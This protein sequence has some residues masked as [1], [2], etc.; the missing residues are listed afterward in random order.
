MHRLLKHLCEITLYPLWQHRPHGIL[1]HYTVAICTNRQKTARTRTPNQICPYFL[2]SGGFR[3]SS[4]ST[5]LAE[6]PLS[7]LRACLSL[8][9]I[10]LPKW[11]RLEITCG[12]FNARVNRLRLPK[13]PSQ[14]WIHKYYMILLF[15]FLFFFPV[16]RD[17]RR[18][19]PHHTHTLISQSL[20]LFLP[21]TFACTAVLCA[22]VCPWARTSIFVRTG[23]SFRPWEGGHLW[24]VRTLWSLLTFWQTFKGAFWGFGLG[25][26]L[27]WC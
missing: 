24:N 6:G 16:F 17:A 7:Q 14:L 12:W 19:V 8:S 20:F 9:R 5:S 2:G 18:S 11:L 26:G 1:V 15:L 4:P 23:L 27:G 21:I 22:R 3:D 13:A 25:S 10:A